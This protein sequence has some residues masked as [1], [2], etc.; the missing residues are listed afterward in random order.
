ARDPPVSGPVSGPASGALLL[1]RDA[2]RGLRRAAGAALAFAIRR[3]ARVLAIG[4]AVAAAGWALDT[5]TRVESDIQ[6]LVPHDLPALRDLDGLQRSSG[7][8]G[9][10][11]VVVEGADVASPASI[12]WMSAFQTAVLKQHGFTETRGC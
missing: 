1:A 5:Q 8:G 2:A 11:D 4:L 6:R 3:P 7:V 9:E 12:A 10:L